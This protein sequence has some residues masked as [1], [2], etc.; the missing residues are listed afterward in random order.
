[1][2][3]LGRYW[4]GR[5]AVAAGQAVVLDLPAAARVSVG[6][7][8]GASG[9]ATVEYTVSGKAL[10]DADTATWLSLIAATSTAAEANRS[11][12]TRALRL[13]ATTTAASFDILQW[14]CD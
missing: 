5:V 12:P 7:N 9:T 10:V 13:T 3:L 14:A 4:E 1:M 2:Q 8:P 6:A 11:V